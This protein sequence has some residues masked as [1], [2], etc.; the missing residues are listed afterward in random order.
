MNQLISQGG[1]SY[2]YDKSGNLVAYNGNSLSYDASNKWTGGTVNGSSV[3][4]GYDGGGRRVRRTV[5]TGRTDY[6]YDSTGLSLET[7]AASVR[8][9]RGQGGELLSREKSG[10]LVNYGTDNLGSTRAL[11]KTDGTVASQITYDPWG[12]EI[13]QTG[14]NWYNPFQY[15]GTYLDEAT[16]MYQM[17]ARYYQPGTGRF[18]QV[19]PINGSNW[20]GRSYDYTGGNPVNFTDPTGLHPV[21]SGYNSRTSGRYGLF[22]MTTYWYF[23]LDHCRTHKLREYLFGMSVTVAISTI[24]MGP[25]PAGVAAVINVSSG[26]VRTWLW[27]ADKGRGVHIWLSANPYQIY[28]WGQ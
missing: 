25:G 13:A 1:T 15:T 7:G 19:D 18:T 14:T 5:G 21:C 27:W 26:V 11:T 9:L 23:R 3:S 16:G 28:I 8:Y 2:T 20:G 12:E 6:W 4:F 10:E 22:N 17:G 24:G